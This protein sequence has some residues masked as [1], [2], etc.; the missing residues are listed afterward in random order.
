MSLP[1]EQ[2]PD[3][4]GPITVLRAISATSSQ[5]DDRTPQT[6]DFSH[7]KKENLILRH[8]K[9]AD[10]S[11]PFRCRTPQEASSLGSNF[12]QSSID[13]SGDH[14][15]AFERPY[16][17]QCLLYIQDPVNFVCQC[18][19]L[20]HH[21]AVA[22]VNLNS[23]KTKHTFMGILVLYA[24][25]LTA[26]PQNAAPQWADELNMTMVNLGMAYYGRVFTPKNC[27][28]RVDSCTATAV[29]Q[30]GPCPGSGVV[31]ILSL[32]EIKKSCSNFK[33]NTTD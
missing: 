10:E 26:G 1:C 32:I 18:L 20:A 28:S 23:R 24:A 21:R 4:Q 13:S 19:G 7:T 12:D 29:V 17:D 14:C 25:P 2:S 11:R 8:E 9:E 30:N 6:S 16:F 27:S 22:H 31:S 5:V 15:M 3:W 33:R